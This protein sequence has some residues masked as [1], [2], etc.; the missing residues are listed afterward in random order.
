MVRANDIA[1]RANRRKKEDREREGIGTD[2]FI[3]LTRLT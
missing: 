1:L 2:Y 3:L